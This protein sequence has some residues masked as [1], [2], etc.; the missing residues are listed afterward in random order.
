MDSRTE[1]FGTN[2]FSVS[3]GGHQNTSQRLTATH[4]DHLIVNGIYMTSIGKLNKR[5]IAEKLMEPLLA[6]TYHVFT[7]D[8]EREWSDKRDLP[9][10][11]PLFGQKVP[12]Y[13]LTNP[14][15]LTIKREGSTQSDDYNPP[16]RDFHG[17][18]KQNTEN[19]F[20]KQPPRW[21]ERPQPKCKRPEYSQ[22]YTKIRID[23]PVI[24]IALITSYLFSTIFVGKLVYNTNTTLKPLHTCLTERQKIS[25]SIVF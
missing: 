8:D 24:M 1:I 3:K 12:K 11:E 13:S 9:I 22:N 16:I 2:M 21:E 14:T 18:N 17:K 20:E 6:K 23:T 15:S 19:S 5:L 7:Q 4:G 10:S 25:T